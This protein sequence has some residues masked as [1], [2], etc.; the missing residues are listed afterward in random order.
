MTHGVLSIAPQAPGVQRQRSAGV[1]STGGG[2]GDGFS[3]AEDE[4]AQG[5]AGERARLS[6]FRVTDFSPEWDS[7]AGGAKMI[8]TGSLL[9]GAPLE[10]QRGPLFLLFDQTEVPSDARAC[11]KRKLVEIAQIG[12]ITHT[13]CSNVSASRA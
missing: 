13:K 9:P 12:D 4:V 2:G 6:A 11:S 10:A 1:A 8:L 3:G 7:T 5:P